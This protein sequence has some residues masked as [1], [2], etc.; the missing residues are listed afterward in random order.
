[1]KLLSLNILLV[2]LS[3]AY[4][5]AQVPQAFSYQAIARDSDGE[6]ISNQNI[7]VKIGIREGSAAGTIIYEETHSSTT[8]EIGIFSIKI[9]NGSVAA[10]NFSTIDWGASVKYLDVSL[11]ISGGSNYMNVGT[12]QLLSVP[13]SLYAEKA[14]ETDPV[15]NTSLA[16]GITEADTTSW[17]SKLE[18]EVDGSTSN[19]IQTIS[20]I[21]TT[22]TLSKDGGSFI[23]SIN[24]FTGD[25]KDNI[26]TNLANPVNDQDAATKAYVDLLKQEVSKLINTNVAGGT[27]TD[28]DGN[29]YNTVK[30][31][32]QIW[33]AENLRT[34]CYTNGE[35]IPN[36]TNNDHWLRNTG[37]RCYY[38]ND[39][40]TYAG[41]YGVLYNW[42]SVVDSRM[43]CPTG[44][45]IPSDTEWT[46]L[47]TY[48]GGRSAAGVKM[49]VTGTA[50]WFCTNPLATNESGFSGL[51]G[52]ERETFGTYININWN[53]TWWSTTEFTGD[54]NEDSFAWN[55]GLYC[56][57]SASYR[58]ESYK[59]Y[60]YSVRCLMD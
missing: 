1:M 34:T 27:L 53:G 43:L 21:G 18:T 7:S 39:S 40:A 6:L 29:V 13:Y 44:W 24:V 36:V 46:T 54:P 22:V 60:G 42:Y 19:E 49:R 11:D 35:S 26:I 3:F 2:L 12:I 51:P 47:E 9:G 28:Y 10:G 57:G 59:S 14:T 38:D 56:F 33:M 48:L 31:G 45:H 25:M 4:A 15:Y 50:H 37:A 20:R 32:S 41:T 16:S 30:I 8:S 55:R 52:G 5:A 17:N 58:Q 23:D